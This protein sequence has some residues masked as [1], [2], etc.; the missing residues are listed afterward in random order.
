MDKQLSDIKSRLTELKAEECRL[1]AELDKALLEAD[2]ELQAEIDRVQSA[3]LARRENIAA[4]L[5]GLARQLGHLPLPS[6]EAAHL[7]YYPLETGSPR[8]RYPIEEISEFAES[9]RERDANA[10]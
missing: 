2:N 5:V 7:D 4:S 10:G 8:S 1:L 9:V 3:H 6:A